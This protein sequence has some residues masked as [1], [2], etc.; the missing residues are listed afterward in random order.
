MRVY[1]VHQRSIEAPTTTVRALIDT[2]ASRHD[3]LWPHETWPDMRFDQPGLTIG[4][5]GG[6]G[7]VGYRVE[8]HEPGRSVL[9]R[10]TGRPVGLWGTHQFL[11]QEAGA[12]SCVLW[13]VTEVEAR[14]RMRLTWFTFWRFLH[15]AL[16]EDS[17]AKAAREAIPDGRHRQPRWNA[18]VR[19]LRRAYAMRLARGR[20]GNRTERDRE[21]YAET[22]ADTSLRL[23]EKR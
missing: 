18:Y 1:N 7:P 12:D 22:P 14:G 5:V 3:R 6:H 9:F 4:G 16:I 15:D 19:F 11:V 8:H 2:L 20:L 23:V 17:L 10:F 21:A 13:H